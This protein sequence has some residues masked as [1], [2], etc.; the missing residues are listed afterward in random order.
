MAIDHSML[1]WMGKQV[2]WYASLQALALSFM[3]ANSI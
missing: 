3:Y 1:E 2:K